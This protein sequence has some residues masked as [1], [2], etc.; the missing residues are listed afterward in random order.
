MR[1]ST[2]R[3]VRSPP[4]LLGEARDGGT[5]PQQ[6]I[7]GT[8]AGEP[9]ASASFF[10]RARRLKGT[11]S[12]IREVHEEY[13]RICSQG[14][15]EDVALPVDASASPGGSSTLTRDILSYSAWLHATYAG[16]RRSTVASAAD[17]D[18][19]SFTRW[20]VGVSSRLNKLHRYY[21]EM[22]SS[23]ASSWSR[24]ASS[25]EDAAAHFLFDVVASGSGGHEDQR[26][27][28]QGHRTQG[29]KLQTITREQLCWV[30]GTLGASNVSFICHTLAS[31][32]T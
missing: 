24:V 22:F 30:M 31:V 11:V 28:Q 19:F 14:G 4:P 25:R 2:R 27:R 10:L 8:Q 26:W 32:L 18:Q 21:D 17:C 16:F 23:S 1:A 9:S 13:D 15:F 3:N 20:I 6:H 29:R 5:T 12:R 7:D